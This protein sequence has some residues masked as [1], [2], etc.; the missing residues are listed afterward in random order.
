MPGGTAGLPI[1]SRKIRTPVTPVQ[2]CVH[3]DCTVAWS[4]LMNE[5]KQSTSWALRTS[6]ALWAAVGRSSE[7][8]KLVPAGVAVGVFSPGVAVAVAIASPIAVR[9]RTV[10]TVWGDV[11]F[12]CR[13]CPAGA[14]VTGRQNVLGLSSIASSAA[15]PGFSEEAWAEEKNSSWLGAVGDGVGETVEVPVGTTPNA[16]GSGSNSRTSRQ[17]TLTDARIVRIRT[18]A[19]LRVAEDRA[20]RVDPSSDSTSANVYSSCAVPVSP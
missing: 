12:S 4:A 10:W 18:I 5:A 3:C 1:E 15:L 7:T 20:G 16:G 8:R 17:P 11:K 9:K 19:M 6:C 2:A 13:Y 14:L